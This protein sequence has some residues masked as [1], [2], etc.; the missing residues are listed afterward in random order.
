MIDHRS[1]YL[2][3]GGSFRD[4]VGQVFISTNKNKVIRGLTLEVFQQQDKLIKESF[5]QQL[6]EDKKVIKTSLFEVMDQENPSSNWHHYIQHELIG[7][8][9]YPYEWS[10]SQL[11][12]AAILQLEVLLKSLENG[13]MIKDATPYN[14]QF[15][16]NKPIFIDTPSFM[17]WDAGMGWEAYRQYCMLFLYPMLLEAYKEIDF[18]PL[19]K[20]NLDGI[21]PNTMMKIFSGRDL[22]RS[23]VF[24]HIF[25]PAKV[26]KNILSN[27]KDRKQAR[28]RKSIQHSKL[29]V[30]ALVESMLRLVKKINN[31]KSISEWGDYDSNNTY[32]DA[33]NQIKK[34]FIKDVASLVNPNIAW[35][36]GANTGLF[37]EHI[38][39]LC[40][41][42][43]ALDQDLNAVDRMYLRIANQGKSNV[44]PLVMQ[45][46]NMSPNHGFAANERV[47][48][49]QR[50]KPDLI[51]CLA[52]IHHIR[53]TANI[54]CKNYL[55]YLRSLNCEVIIEFVNR[56]DEMVI[57][58][59]KNKHEQYLDY[60][61]NTFKE[62]VVK[63]F[64]IKSSVKLKNGM[65][66]L[67]HLTP[68]DDV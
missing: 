46:N 59:L 10:F 51:M 49:E 47:S 14:I 26:E 48:L 55:S 38:S 66:E 67:F 27:E 44:T 31:K 61:I 8:I 40:K 21:E 4:P 60:N 12:N 56:D 63:S 37:S 57:K 2:A 16:E 28:D 65:R 64:E 30:I 15:K 39:S 52:V 35:D 7:P 33:D 53:M 13:W 50:A 6:I 62:E 1:S 20:S 3:D 29:S 9:T 19:L 25:L 5:F 43:I 11:K 36:M 24:S 32:E 54:P 68:K 22:F 18:R 45:L 58:L 23:G 42:V 34:N 17:P 41:S